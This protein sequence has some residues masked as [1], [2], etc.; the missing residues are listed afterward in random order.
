MTPS[1]YAL[2]RKDFAN[3][4]CR[5]DSSFVRKRLMGEPVTVF[6]RN[7]S[8]DDLAETVIEIKRSL[9]DIAEKRIPKEADYLEIPRLIAEV[10]ELMIKFSDYVRENKVNQKRKGA[11]AL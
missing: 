8:L 3:S 9:D 10:K 1:E 7:Q 6:Y 5:T 2:F 4:A 11:T